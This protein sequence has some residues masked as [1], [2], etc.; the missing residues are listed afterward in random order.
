MRQSPL[1]AALGALVEIGSMVKKSFISIKNRSLEWL[2][3]KLPEFRK[4][5]KSKY[6]SLIFENYY[7]RVYKNQSVAAVII[8]LSKKR[9]WL[10]IVSLIPTLFMT[11]DS[12]A[13]PIGALY[14]SLNAAGIFYIVFNLYP[15]VKLSFR[16]AKQALH[17]LSMIKAR[18]AWLVNEL[19]GADYFTE[20][21]RYLSEN[22]HRKMIELL[23]KQN[24]YKETVVKVED[25]VRSGH[26][27]YGVNPPLAIEVKGHFSF[28]TNEVRTLL[29]A[30]YVIN[31][32]NLND[33]Q[34]LKSIPSIEQLN[35]YDSL[36][37]LEE[38]LEHFSDKLTY[39]LNESDLVAYFIQA[40]DKVNYYAQIE[41]PF[42][43]GQRYDLRFEP[44]KDEL[45][46]AKRLV[47]KLFER[48]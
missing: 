28:S 5:L 18:R 47:T 4:W 43:V 30:L 8:C 24:G 23:R 9:F 33:L 7:D 12:L 17:P 11:S 3:V 29:E 22:T 16:A 26:I 42:Y 20:A 19:T 45:K 37:Y 38:E 25:N 46:V 21:N 15:E 1:N 35:L 44:T 10:V 40:V 39:T 14:V 27:S 34:K 31:E 6:S 41:M 32:Q 13:S 2:K 48:T 36:N